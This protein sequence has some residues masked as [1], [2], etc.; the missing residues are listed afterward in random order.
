MA[1]TVRRYRPSG[2]IR[3]RSVHLVSARLQFSLLLEVSKPNNITDA[4]TVSGRIV[5]DYHAG[6]KA[7]IRAV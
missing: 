1:V 7:E 4:V 3:A 5:L 6:G 2:H